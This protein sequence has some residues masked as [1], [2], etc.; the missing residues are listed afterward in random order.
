MKNT[1]FDIAHRFNVLAPAK[2]RQFLDALAAQGIDFSGLPIV[3]AQDVAVTPASYAQA[4]MWFLWKLEPQSAAYHISGAWRLHGA[5]DLGALRTG[6][7]ALVE[8]HAA[9]RTVFK[10]GPEGLPLQCVL[11]H[12]EIDIPV[13]EAEQPAAQM[14]SLC[15]RSFDLETGPL[16][17]VVLI[18]EAQDRHLLVVVMHH[19]VSD[20]R[21]MQIL[22][23]EFA[24]QYAAH[25]QSLAAGLP[26]LPVQ[27]ADYALWQRNWMEAGERD[28]QL[29]YWTQQ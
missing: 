18:R 28:R 11:E 16:L 27:Y 23:E 3:P 6:F 4:R 13:V 24:A 19:I 22:M 8:R 21:S 14:Q 17:R 25:V 1:E 15:H 5:L 26:S 29:A 20:G 12:V 10:A 9:L 7:A 2:R